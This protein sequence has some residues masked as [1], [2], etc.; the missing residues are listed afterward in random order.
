M[1][2]LR[3]HG[4]VDMALGRLTRPIGVGQSDWEPFEVVDG[5]TYDWWH[6]PIDWSGS[7]GRF[8]VFA[9]RVGGD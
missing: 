7:G 9:A 5:F 6:R 3:D 8:E 2:Y 1:R 4:S